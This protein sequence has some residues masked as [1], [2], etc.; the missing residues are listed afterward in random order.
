MRFNNGNNEGNFE[1]DADGARLDMFDLNNGLYAQ[2][3]KDQF[4][5]ERTAD[6]YATYSQFDINPDGVQWRDGANNPLMPLNDEHLVV[7]KYVD[8]AGDALQANIDLKFNKAGGAIDTN[9]VVTFDSSANNSTLSLGAESVQLHYES[10]D[11]VSEYLLSNYFEVSLND[12]ASGGST[13]F[14]VDQDVISIQRSADNDATWVTVDFNADGISMLDET[15]APVMPQADEHLVVKKYVDD[16][17]AGLQDSVDELYDKSGIVAG[18]QNTY[19]TTNVVANGDSLLAAIGK[20]DDAL[21]DVAGKSYH[22]A[23][24]YEA[25]GGETSLNKPVAAPAIP[26]SAFTEVYIDGRKVFRGA[27][28]QFTVAVG[29]GSIDFAALT[30]GQTVEL[31]YFA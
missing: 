12:S 15:L 22:E 21:A 18:T 27:D 23:F 31:R 5:V 14:R 28:K 30:A 13:G 20:I 29:G 8:D 17:D 24:I 10:G 26:D 25:V 11:L 3:H 2:F 6:N 4:H 1:V 16:A 19:S 7:K 9:G